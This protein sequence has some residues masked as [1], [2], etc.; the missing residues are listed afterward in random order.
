MNRGFYFWNMLDSLYTHF[1][2]A[3]SVSTDSRSIT[4]GCIFF[5]LK[6]ANFNGNQF[7]AQALELGAS[8][9]I[10][11]EPTQSNDS[12][13]W[14]VDNVLNTLQQLALKH[15]MTFNIP[16]LAVTGSNGKTTTKELV[17]DVLSKR[18]RVHATRGNLNNHI[19]I[20]LTLLATHLDAEIA[21]IE[22]GANHQKEIS[23]Y[24][25]YTA[26]N[27][28]L[29]TNMGKAHLEGFGGEAGVIQG[30]KELYDYLATHQGK[31]FVNIELPHLA[32]SSREVEKITYGFHQPDFHLEILHENPVLSYEFKSTR[33]TKATTHLVGAY[34][35]YNI[36]SAIAV[37]RY[38]QVKDTDIHAAIST[39]RPD[40]N[41]SQLVHTQHNSVIMDAYNANP[42]S[43]ATAL[44]SLSHQQGN[45]PYIILGDMRE[46]GETSPQEHRE[47][48]QLATQLSLK[49]IVIGEQFYH[50]ATDF[51]FFA[52]PDI[53]T[54]KSYLTSHPIQNK[55]ILLK[56]SRGMHLEDLMPHL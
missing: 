39:Y 27:Y 43:M 18:Y 7:A 8:L 2:T 26:P 47:I 22:M 46:L 52:F 24:C 3:K 42:S 4:P 55:T 14:R 5:A 12:R 35:L 37:G 36:A 32:D 23:S 30:K 15:R 33:S 10:V 53:N 9:A 29:I 13:I 45:Q 6:G 50:A 19:G 48:L 11:D 25:E 38:F 28:G 21:I 20:P 49:G 54:A 31:A 16:F 40:N 17:R 44:E 1:L 34:N 41:R 56:G 51:N